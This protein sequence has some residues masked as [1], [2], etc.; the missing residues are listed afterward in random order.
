MVT[1][2]RPATALLCTERCQVLSD[3][4]IGVTEGMHSAKAFSVRVDDIN[5]L[6]I[7]VI[8]PPVRV[9]IFEL[10]KV[11]R[12]DTPRPQEFRSGWVESCDA[13]KLQA[14]FF[15]CLAKESADMGT[16]RVADAMSL[17]PAK[18]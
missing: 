2:D 6:G 8:Q 12:D 16:N 4:E 10:L 17:D 7:C 11:P 1:I 14:N 5:M 9:Q 3:V 15:Q 13:I 18:F